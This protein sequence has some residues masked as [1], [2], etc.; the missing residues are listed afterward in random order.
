MPLRAIDMKTRIIKNAT[1]LNV[2]CME[3]MKQL[4]DKYFDLAI[5]DPPYG[6]GEKITNGGTWAAKLTKE[7]SAWDTAPTKDFFNELRR[8]SKEQIIWGG[9]YFELPPTRCFLIWDKVA[10]MDTL[11]DCELAWT[12]MDKNAKIFKHVRN[13][14]EQRIHVC[15]KPIKLY[16]WLLTNYA[17]P[18]Q[19]IFDSHMG[20]GSSAIAANNLG[21]EF[22]GCELDEDYFDAACKRIEQH[23]QQERLFA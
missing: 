10:H 20:S 11:A 9:N 13:T 12:S 3:Y 1:I 2:D 19:K 4:P 17:K 22:V 5:V 8:V 21:F 15:Q 14:A 7:D 6:L 16:E 18:G 23:A